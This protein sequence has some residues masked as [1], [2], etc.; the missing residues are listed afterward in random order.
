MQFYAGSAPAP[1]APSLV[2]PCKSIALALTLFRDLKIKGKLMQ[3]DFTIKCARFL[4]FSWLVK[5]CIKNY[6]IKMTYKKKTV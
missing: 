3:A 1:M 5:N 4:V 6:R 2:A